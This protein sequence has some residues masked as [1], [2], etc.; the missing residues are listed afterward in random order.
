M[1]ICE[2]E[3]DNET[4]RGTGVKLR[5]MLVVGAANRLPVMIRE[6]KRGFI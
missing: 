6:N 2:E 5:V 3:S 1:R 4:I